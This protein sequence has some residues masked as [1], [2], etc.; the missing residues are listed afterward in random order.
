MTINTSQETLH[1]P[2]HTDTAIDI[3]STLYSFLV[4]KIVTGID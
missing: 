3:C 2:M 4:F 1:R